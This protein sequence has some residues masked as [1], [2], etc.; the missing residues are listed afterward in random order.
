MRRWWRRCK[1]FCRCNGMGTPIQ[2]PIAEQ[3]AV[4]QGVYRPHWEIG[5]IEIRVSRTR[6]LLIGAAISCCLLAMFGLEWLSLIPFLIFGAVTYF[7]CFL[8]SVEIWK[9]HFPAGLDDL[10]SGPIEFEGVVSPPGIYGHMGMMHREVLIQ[11]VL[12]YC[13]DR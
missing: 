8:P 2:K 13:K 10:G 1:N 4:Y 9:P 6:K 7:Y 3:L 12:K 5:H 11:R